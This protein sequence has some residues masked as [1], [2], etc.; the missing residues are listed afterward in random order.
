M[1]IVLHNSYLSL[2]ESMRVPHE[3]AHVPAPSLIA[4]NEPLARQLGLTAWRDSAAERFSGNLRAKHSIP[5]ALAYAGHQFG[6]FVP[7]LGDGRALLLG[8]RIDPDGRRFDLQLKGSGRTAFSRGGDGKSPLGPVLREYLISEAMAALGVPTTRSLAAVA[9][10]EPVVRETSQPGA[11]LTRVASSHLR[12][13][14]F[15]FAAAR[16]DRGALEA[17]VDFALRR[18]VPEPT[19][20]VPALALFDYV[21]DAQARLTA[22]WMALGFVHGVMNTDNTTISGETIDYGPCAF[23]DEYAQGKVFSSI[24]V[25]GR[26][27]YGQQAS[28][29]AWNLSRLAGCLLLIHDDRSVFEERIE[30]YFG[31][32]EAAY[33]A[34]MRA[35][36]GLLDDHE[37]DTALL[38]DWLDL[39][40]SNGLDYHVS[41]HDLADRLGQVTVD[42][43][44]P[45]S[46]FADRWSQRLLG[47]DRA[48]LADLR[49]RMASANPAVIPRNHQVALA[50][51]HAEQGDFTTFFALDE[52]LRRPFDPALV[53]SS[54]AEPP[55]PSLR[56]TRTFCGT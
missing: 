8:E 25:H 19:S 50:I 43:G 12:V 23:L 32:W 33:M 45:I 55:E 44:D 53:E 18:H 54:F 48:A 24:D 6:H 16:G 1:A 2:P 34:R 40:E 38:K 37:D 17:L 42:A 7:S 3:A 15:E 5:V 21:V 29:A 13:G 22:Q 20:D 35:R 51:E 52:A 9:T 36:F 49:T 28:I 11:I 26:Y 56:V 31:T 30:G 46:G 27:A 4:W 47:A 39:L 10:G 41:W 14:T